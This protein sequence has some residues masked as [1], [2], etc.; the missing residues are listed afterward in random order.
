MKSA[1]WRH[2]RGHLII[3]RR[4][5]LP[6]LQRFEV[7]DGRTLVGKFSDVIRAEVCVDRRLC[8]EAGEQRA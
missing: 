1:Y 8:G 7:W 4:G 6:G 2:Y 5:C 3:K